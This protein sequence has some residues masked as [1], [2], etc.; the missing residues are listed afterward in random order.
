MLPTE[1][2]ER[3]IPWLRNVV[4]IFLPSLLIILLFGVAFDYVLVPT[5]EKVLTYRKER[6]LHDIADMA[7]HTVDIFQNKELADL[8]NRDTLQIQALEQ[9]SKIRLGLNSTSYFWVTDSTSVLI[10]HPTNPTYI[11]LDAYENPGPDGTYPIRKTYEM[12]MQ[13]G[14]GIVTYSWFY[15]DSTNRIERKMAHSMF[16]EPWGWVISNG[17]YLTDIREETN[18]LLWL[19][20]KAAIAISALIILLII[21][22]TRS[23][24]TFERER[25]RAEQRRE[26]LLVELQNAVSRVDRLGGL[27]PICSRCKKV[28]DD[29]GYWK[30]VE[31]YISDHFD[32]E[33]SHGLCPDCQA[34]AYKELDELTF[35]VKKKGE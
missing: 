20:R 16:Y 13:N 30:N 17:A 19:L 7:F 32:T 9:L 35:D 6:A 8:S 1:N 2:I 29:S 12:A 27:L 21:H 5:L 11:G 10:M 24:F 22:L 3:R 34:D 4:K 25:I 33:F 18:Q 31:Q 26:T 14:H 23:N 15:P 28:R